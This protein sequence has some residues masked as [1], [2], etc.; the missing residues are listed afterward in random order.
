MLIYGHRGARGEA[1]ENTLP[2]FRKALEAGVTRVELDLH[3]SSDHQLMV[4][5]D[6]TLK[7]TTGIK[8]KIAA[9][10]AAQL[11]RLDARLGLPGWAEPCPIPTLEQLFRSCPEFDHYQLEVKSGSAAQSR[12]VMAAVTPLVAEFGLQDKVVITSSSRTLLRHVQQQGYGLPTGLVE[13][14]GFLDPVKSALRYGCRFLV[15]NWKLCTPA[16]VAQAQREGLHVSVWTVNEPQLMLRLRDMGIDSLITDVPQL[17]MQ[18][19][20]EAPDAT[21]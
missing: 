10:T 8:G 11:M 7:R 9:H 2:S 12:R 20:G 4:I 16:R 21:R 1:P 14:Y 5:H 13:E 17:A 19:L 3:L 6:P 18:V 15:L